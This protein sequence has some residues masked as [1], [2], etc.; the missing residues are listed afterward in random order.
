MNLIL[1][2]PAEVD[3]AGVARLADKRAEHIRNVLRAEPG[4]TIRVG[5][6]NGPLGRGTVE[7]V[8]ANSV[9]LACAFEAAPPP[10]PP[11]DLLLAMPRPKVLK[12]LWAQFAALGVGRIFITSAQKVEKYYFDTHILTPDFYRPRLI[13]GLQQARDT[14]LP[15]VEIIKNL[16]QLLEQGPHAPA[17]LVAD[18]SATQ[19]VFQCLEPVPERCLLAIGPEGGWTAGELQL[20][21]QHDFER[22]GI[23]KRILRT[24]TACIALISLLAE[25]LN[26]S[27]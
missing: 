8:S 6:L 3:F 15:E 7:N 21:E 5:L 24:D 19:T 11:I 20:F 25:G 26:K 4:K 27:V 2:H 16:R 1:I 10:R 22:V 18:P 9:T 14:H 13:E 12:R 17:Q 23:G